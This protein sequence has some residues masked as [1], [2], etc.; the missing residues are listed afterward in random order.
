[1]KKVLWICNIMLPAIGRELNLPYSNREGWLSG[2]FEKVM[3]KEVPFTLGIAFPV[4][5]LKE[6]SVLGERIINSRKYGWGYP[7]PV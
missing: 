5:D 1:M 7:G 4:K 6:F 3:N 2:I